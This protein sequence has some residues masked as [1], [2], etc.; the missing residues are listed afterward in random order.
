[1]NTNDDH[2]L[3]IDKRQVD[4]PDLGAEPDWLSDADIE[5]TTIDDTTAPAK[6]AADIP[7]QEIK[8]EIPAAQSGIPRE[9][10]WLWGAVPLCLVGLAALIAWLSTLQSLDNTTI[11][12]ELR[13]HEIGLLPSRWSMLMWW[14]VLPVLAIF[15][16]WAITPG[17]RIAT[18]IKIT[19]PLVSAAVVATIVWM[20]AQIWQWEWIGFVSI[21][22]ATGL[23][24]ICHLAAL[25]H[26]KNAGQSWQ[27]WLTV[28]ALGASSAYS[29]MLLVITYQQTLTQPF[30]VRGT[31]LLILTAV[32]IVS[33]ILSLFL[34]DGVF[35]LV[36]TI[37]FIGIAQ[38]QWSTDKVLS[39]AAIVALVLTAILTVIGVLL[40]S[41]R[42]H[43][44]SDEAIMSHRSRTNFF[45][46]AK[47]PVS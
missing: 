45:R 23:V 32:L 26:H 38:M 41:E 24:L 28:G 15:L 13:T 22:I 20:F 5:T 42:P 35:A 47:E 36:V 37:W 46:R 40:A 8:T 11:W 12:A 4:E 31:S 1:M 17:G 39:F 2:D 7:Q 34:R 29:L 33:A 25:L 21:G 27:R 14:C 44:E 9:R 16:V 18:H 43:S 30:G 19:G 10:P 3:P 6:V